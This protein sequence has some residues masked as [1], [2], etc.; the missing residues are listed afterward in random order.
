MERRF[1]VVF[2]NLPVLTTVLCAVP[3]TAFAWNKTVGVP[4]PGTVA[5]LALGLTGIAAYRVKRRS[6]R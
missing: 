1:Q 6:R 3:I 5:L 4:E 2:A